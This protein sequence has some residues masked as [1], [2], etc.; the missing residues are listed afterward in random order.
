[1]QIWL[2]EK[3]STNKNK[4][5]KG[6][7]PMQTKGESPKIPQ[8]TKT[9]EHKEAENRCRRVFSRVSFAQNFTVQIAF[10]PAKKKTEQNSRKK[11]ADRRKVAKREKKYFL[12]LPFLL[13]T[14]LHLAT[15][16]ALP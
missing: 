3:D 2:I 7:I 14:F 11:K 9:E 6:E 8:Q 12:F 4:G 5:E 10:D 1:M 13:A 15:Q 16:I